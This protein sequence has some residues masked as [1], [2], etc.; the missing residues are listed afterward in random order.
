M[1]VVAF[2]ITLLKLFKNGKQAGYII[3]II[4]TSISVFIYII[5]ELLSAGIFE[6]NMFTWFL[7]LLFVVIHTLLLSLYQVIYVFQKKFIF[8]IIFIAGLITLII[9]TL[10]DFLNNNYYCV[11]FSNLFLIGMS[12]FSY[13]EFLKIKEPIALNKNHSFIVVNGIFYSSCLS[14]PIYIFGNLIRG[15]ISSNAYYYVSIVSP[16]SSIILYYMIIRSVLCIRTIKQ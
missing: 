10:F 2:L 5:Q 6:K 13:K 4:Y 11:T 15:S 8:Q 16:L 9:F 12:L 14:L 7:V 1:L 3:L